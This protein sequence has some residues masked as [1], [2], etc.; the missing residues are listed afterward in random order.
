MPRINWKLKKI[1]PLQADL[2]ETF[3]KWKS[4]ESAILAY[5]YQSASRTHFGELKYFRKADEPSGVKTW[6]YLA[7]K[8]FS[9]RHAMVAVAA[10]LKKA[11]YDEKRTW[12]L[13]NCRPHGGTWEPDFWPDGYA[14]SQCGLQICVW[15]WMRRYETLKKIIMTPHNEPLRDNHNH[16]TK[17]LGLSEPLSITRFVST[18]DVLKSRGMYVHFTLG[19]E[20]AIKRR[21]ERN[22]SIYDRGK[23]PEFK[24]ALKL[25]G[26]NRT[27]SVPGLTISYLHNEPIGDIGSKCNINDVAGVIQM[28]RHAH[29]SIPDALHFCQPYPIWLLDCDETIIRFILEGVTDLPTYNR[30]H[31]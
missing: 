2:F 23:R 20:R 31:L 7:R 6:E 28:T 25:L 22:G 27:D 5:G 19:V 17:G 8:L 30:R 13:A 11:G 1:H 12:L 10:K 26:I 29:V 4:T 24:R 14:G 21:L 16:K 9:F 15:C 18:A 3:K